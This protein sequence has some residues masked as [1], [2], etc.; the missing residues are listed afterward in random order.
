MSCE[1]PT[2]AASGVVEAA[3]AL[4]IARAVAGEAAALLRNVAGSAERVRTKSSPKD[5]VTEWDLRSEELIRERLQA[6]TPGIA[7][8]G[9]EHGHSA[10]SGA[11]TVDHSATRDAD[12]YR[13][14]I[15]PIDGTVNFLHGVP[16]FAVALALELDGE[17]VAGVVHAPALDWQFYGHL[18]G[19]AFMNGERLAVSR[20]DALDRALV[21]TGFPYDRATSRNN[22]FAR[23]ERLQ[24][25]AGACRRF[26]SASLDLC[27]VARGWVDGYWESGLGP[28]DSSGGA[29]LVREAGGVVTALGG[30]RFE[31][32]KGDVL[33][34]NGGIHKEMLHELASA[35]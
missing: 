11:G 4:D 8:L 15:D 21:S 29:L 13:W 16:L 7:L 5:P 2:T 27:M 33:A 24:R 17:P 23:W 3:D 32:A 12:G 25:S 34:S 6:R 31:S 14:L 30:G 35:D 26:G 28:W 10:G 18:G 1:S 20:V 22:N 9:E 19:G